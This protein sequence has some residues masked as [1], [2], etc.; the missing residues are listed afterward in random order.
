MEVEER[1]LRSRFASLVSTNHIS[2]TGGTWTQT[3]DYSSI[4]L[5]SLFLKETFNLP[6]PK[7]AWQS[8]NPDLLSLYGYE[9]VMLSNLPQEEKLA[10]QMQFVWKG[11]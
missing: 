11:Q 8:H 3:S 2:F 1:D 10:K 5:G 6:R 9:S 4:S 7:I